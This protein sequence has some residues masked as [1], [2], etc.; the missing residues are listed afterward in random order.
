LLPDQSHFSLHDEQSFTGL[1]SLDS[2]LVQQLQMHFSRLQAVLQSASESGIDRVTAEEKNRVNNL[3]NDFNN[4]QSRLQYLPSGFRTCQLLFRHLQ[5]V[6]LEYE[7][8]VEYLTKYKSRMNQHTILPDVTSTV[9]AYV[10]SARDAHALFN[11]GI[12]FWF[13]RPSSEICSVR[14]DNVIPLLSPINAGL[15][16]A[17]S[18]HHSVIFNGPSSDPGKYFAMSEFTRSLN[19]YPDPFTTQGTPE[20][21]AA[22]ASHN[23]GTGRQRYQALTKVQ[24]DMKFA[25]PCMFFYVFHLQLT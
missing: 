4:I 5:R 3:A 16:V 24:R 10:F 2:A 18:P 13:I 23:V 25:S 6:V 19:R 7:A 21:L 15:D 8:L 20:M 17:P 9:G 22:I 14:V 12:P 11:A 1:G